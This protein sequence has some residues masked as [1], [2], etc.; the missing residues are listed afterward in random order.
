MT[1]SVD[2]YH[3]NR[4]D[5]RSEYDM[6]QTAVSNGNV[7]M[8]VYGQRYAVKDIVFIGTFDQICPR[9]CYQG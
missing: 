9:N 3:D 8:A 6:L 4:I 5:L 7:S 2:S 1:F